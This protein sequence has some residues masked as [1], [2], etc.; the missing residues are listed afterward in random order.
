MNILII[1][2]IYPE[3]KDYDIPSDSKAVHYFARELVSAGNNVTV[4]HLYSSPISRINHIRRHWFSIKKNVQ[5]GVTVICGKVQLFIPHRYS[6]FKNQ[7]L[8]MAKKFKTYAKEHNFRYDLIIVHFPTTLLWFA[9]EIAGNQ[10]ISCVMHGV[11]LR[12][13]EK[14][15]VDKQQ[16]YVEVIESASKVISYR[17]FALRQRAENIGF[18]TRKSNVLYSGIPHEMIPEQTKV[19]EKI[20][21]GFDGKIIFA[22]KINRQKRVDLIL[23]AISLSKSKIEC[24]V[25]GDGPERKELEALAKELGIDNRVSFLGYQERNEVARL[26][27]Q[28]DI[29]TMIS[30]NETMGLVYLEAMAQ[31]CITIG[32]RGEGIDGVIRNGE[33]GFLV[34]PNSPEKLS[35]MIDRIATMSQ[36]ERGAIQRN[37]H[38]TSVAMSDNKMASIYLNCLLG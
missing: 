24:Y 10:K 14:L 5:D 16:R 37:A 12:E 31:G 7:Q 26:M 35:D 13:L 4:Y 38:G 1:T 2:S 33:N 3:P 34:E 36:T 8:R 28:S 6:G 32:T 18:D 20:R 29:F 11:D 30:Q 15:Q 27:Y 19:E 21:H 9:K 17:S 25:V 22:G 23:K